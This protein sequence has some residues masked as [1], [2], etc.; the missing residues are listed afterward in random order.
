MVTNWKISAAPSY[1]RELGSGTS[2]IPVFFVPVKHTVVC[3]ISFMSVRCGWDGRSSTQSDHL[4]PFGTNRTTD[5][6]YYWCNPALYVLSPALVAEVKARWQVSQNGAQRVARALLAAPFERVIEG[7]I[8]GED[9]RLPNMKDPNSPQ[10][11]AETGGASRD[12][13]DSE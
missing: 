7:A 6:S 3:L 10:L 1:C 4:A 2:S 11:R 9:R 8:D 12:R 13:S 5:E